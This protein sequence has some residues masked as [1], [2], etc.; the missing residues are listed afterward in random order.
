MRYGLLSILRTPL[1]T[2]LFLLL[3]A[4]ITAFLA[5]GAGMWQSAERMLADADDTF[6]SA[7]E[8][9]YVGGNYPD[10]LVYD[11]TLE[12]A[13][14]RV[15]L[16]ALSSAEG[17]KFFEESY[18]LRAT[19]DGLDSWDNPYGTV[20]ILIVEAGPY[21]EKTASYRCRVREHIYSERDMDG[22]MVLVFPPEEMPDYEFVD[23]N[24]YLMLGEFTAED[25]F[26]ECFR[27]MDISPIAAA[28]G[29]PE[30]SPLPCLMD[31]TDFTEADWAAFWADERGEYL[32]K[33]AE[34]FSIVNHAVPL[35]ATG[36][37]MAVEA[38]HRGEI[39]WVGG[40]AFTEADYAAGDA[41]IV[42]EYIALKKNLA[43]GDTLRLDIHRPT[44]RQGLYDSYW[45]DAGFAASE[46]FRVIGIYRGDGRPTTM[47]AAAGGQPWLAHS[48]GDYTLARVVLEN[49][50]AED[51]LLA[52]EGALPDNVRL[53]FYDQGYEAAA[54]PIMS[55]R[56][57]AVLITVIC[58]ASC[59]IVL[60]F[61]AYLFVFRNAGAAA[62]LLSLGSGAARVR[63][64]L[65]SGCSAIAACAAAV[66]G[67]AGFFLSQRVTGIVYESA[68]DN[69][70]FDRRFSS[71]G[72]GILSGLFVGT[73]SLDWRVYLLTAAAV[74]L[75]SV[76][77]CLLFAGQTIRAQSPRVKW[78]RQAR[79]HRRSKASGA[80]A[81]RGRGAAVFDILPTATLRYAAKSVFRGGR[82]S[83]VVP[84]AVAAMLAFICLFSGMRAEYGRQLDTVYENVPVTMR[85]TDYRGKRIDSLIIPKAWV[86]ELEGSGFVEES[87]ASLNIQY[88]F[89]GLLERADG[90][91]VSGELHI[92]EVPR[93]A[94]ESD[95]YKETKFAQRLRLDFKNM[96]FCGSIPLTP[97]FVYTA[98]PQVAYAPGYDE[99][100]FA[101]PQ[102]TENMPVCFMPASFMEANDI[103]MGDTAQ[104]TLYMYRHGRVY[105]AP[106][107]FVVAG[108]FT[109]VSGQDTLYAPLYDSIF[110]EDENGET[111]EFALQE[112]T[113]SYSLSMQEY[114]VSIEHQYQSV[115]FLL[116]DTSSMSA[117]KNWLAARYSQV[118]QMTE[119]RRWV[120]IEDAAL[121][122][123][124]ESLQRY[125]TYMNLLYPV[126]LFVSGFIGFLLSTLLLKSRGG[127]I[128]VMRGVG[129]R[130]PGI[131]LSFFFEQLALCLPGIAAGVAVVAPILGGLAGV[132]PLDVALFA[133]C[134]LLGASVAIRQTMNHSVLSH[135]A[136]EE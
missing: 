91:E 10:A 32:S 129:G 108:S 135:F 96:A 31:V 24:L 35:V 47:Y 6:L 45:P 93:S 84:L 121:Y 40:R 58:A 126:V 113:A 29:G 95:R 43:V 71:S 46:D 18:L 80:P 90:S 106:L 52:A 100:V 60:I 98:S 57:T 119:N 107:R 105:A 109:G 41:L 53:N 65:L 48:A 76:A 28:A 21:L 54:L 69:A 42:S 9:V 56:E 136:R 27:P 33:T 16:G 89:D 7:G 104:I 118:N 82:R 70:L 64:Y 30:V 99:G 66:G 78:R 87:G 75:L 73:P 132:G 112:R 134:Y 38:F 123:T 39:E 50:V 1:K 55:M 115:G 17:V 92:I 111:R 5:L 72:Y 97:E 8:F 22:R 83:L 102:A 128:T 13:A 101:D 15:D 88:H 34:M 130:K 62:T 79:R 51:Y 23:G 49:R 11:E 114:I 74:A 20:G 26:Y 110:F 61:F 122:R 117:F 124:V 120:V 44:G 4:V 86:D 127:E 94:D 81:R 2:V 77:L 14:S 133:A 12:E 68:L 36:D 25:G 63:A 103:R 85:I 3:I 116:K 131:F 59:L 37:V 19:I 125:I 67:V